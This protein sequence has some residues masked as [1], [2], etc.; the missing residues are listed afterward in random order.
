[1]EKQVR[2][3]HPEGIAIATTAAFVELL[4]ALLF[5]DGD[6]GVD[7]LL[8]KA[9]KDAVDVDVT[10]ADL[11]AADIDVISFADGA[12]FQTHCA[13]EHAFPALIHLARKYPTDAG[14]ALL[15][16]TNIGGDNVHRSAGLGPI[17]GLLAPGTADELFGQLK[18]SAAIAKEI[19]AVVSTG[20]E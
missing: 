3:T 1:V 7:A 10:V 12:K 2:L 20:S 18:H 17:T 5:R 4:D 11:A 15:A 16:N 9:A 8:V 6:D 14:V 13:L 19:A